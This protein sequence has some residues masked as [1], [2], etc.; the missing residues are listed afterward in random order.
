MHL[1]P[2][3]ILSSSKWNQ[4]TSFIVSSQLLK[5]SLERGSFFMNLDKPG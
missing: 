2:L 4:A 5:K 1:K 3:V